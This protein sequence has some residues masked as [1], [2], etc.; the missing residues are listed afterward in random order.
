MDSRRSSSSGVDEVTKIRQ[1]HQSL[2]QDYLVLQKECVSKKRK[3]KESKEK[4]D[5]LLDEIRFLKRRRNLLLRL[6]SPNS[7]QQEDFVESQKTHAK[8]EVGPS[9]RYAGTS[10]PPLQN[11]RPTTGSIW[12]SASL[13]NE[14]VG[15]PSVK[16]GKKPKDLF[17]N[18]KRAE[19]RK[20]SWQDPLALK[21]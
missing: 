1:K 9:G 10:E 16:L 17:T 3:L 4:K 11:S 18:G 8:Y 5:T 20:I 13:A 2:L 12:N 19:K 14:E 15:F 21:V 7:E 6:Q